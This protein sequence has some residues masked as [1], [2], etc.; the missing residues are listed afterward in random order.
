MGKIIAKLWTVIVRTFACLLLRS[1]LDHRVYLVLVRKIWKCHQTDWRADRTVSLRHAGCISSFKILFDLFYLFLLYLFNRNINDHRKFNNLYRLFDNVRYYHRK[2]VQKRFG[3]IFC[4]L[5]MVF[6]FGTLW[7]SHSLFFC[8]FLSFLS[9][10]C[11]VSLFYRDLFLGTTNKS[12]PTNA[13]P[14]TTDDGTIAIIVIVVT[15]AVIFIISFVSILFVDFC[16]FFSVRSFCFR[17]CTFSTR[18]IWNAIWHRWISIIPCIARR[19]KINFPWRKI[20]ILHLGRIWV[21]WVKR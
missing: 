20:N 1:I 3:V 14:E 2:W 9:A 8:L 13:L 6:I 16:R 11:P 15:L 10:I 18:N 17:W 12:H 21:R 7:L 5:V 4:L 19:Q